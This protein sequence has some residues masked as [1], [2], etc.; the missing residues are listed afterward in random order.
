MYLKGSESHTESPKSEQFSNISK[1]VLLKPLY[2]SAAM[3]SSA[4]IQNDSTGLYPYNPSHALP[5]VFAVLVGASLFLHIY[6][7]L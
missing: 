7:N 3:P 6:Q 2:T 5:I 4:P 1:I